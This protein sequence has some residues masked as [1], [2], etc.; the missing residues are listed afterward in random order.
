MAVNGHINY[1]LKKFDM[2][3]IKKDKL[4]V[5]IGKRDTGKST[6]VKDLL[7]YQRDIP[8]GIVISG[9]QAGIEDYGKNVPPLYIYGEY[10]KNIVGKLIDNQSRKVK[11]KGKENTKPVFLIMD[12]CL[13][14]DKWA[15]DKEMKYIFFN[16]RHINTLFILTMQYPLGIG[17][18]MRSNID[19]VFILRDTIMKNRKIIYEN[20]AGMFPSFDIFCSVMNQCTENYEC[21]VIHNNSKSNKFEDQVFWYKA[22]IHDNFKVG[23]SK[24]WKIS[25]RKYNDR[26]DEDDD[27]VYVDIPR[28][29]PRIHVQKMN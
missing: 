20:Y 6:L 9:T 1:Q 2:R 16:G 14:D 23:S 26:Y 29:K 10:H 17:P 24:F 27:N 8:S 7:Y 4:C 13:H 5:F 25:D 19:F 3:W 21:L 18:A 11:K 15:K 28:R 22:E 12:D